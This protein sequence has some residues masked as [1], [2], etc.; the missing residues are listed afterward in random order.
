MESA[1]QFKDLTK[2]Y[3]M[4]GEHIIEI[5]KRTRTFN[6]ITSVDVVN[7]LSDEFE[8][9]CTTS[10]H[11][12]LGFVKCFLRRYHTWTFEIPWRSDKT[13]GGSP[14]DRM[15]ATAL[16]DS[17]R[18]PPPGV[19]AETGTQR[20]FEARQSFLSPL[21]WTGLSSSRNSGQN[22]LPTS[23]ETTNIVQYPRSI[24]TDAL[25]VPYLGCG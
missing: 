6:T 12:L 23:R 20:R 10:G 1:E 14:E 18:F 9:H 5:L 19:T 17:F 8:V 13:L 24:R 3:T 15:S 7:S 2:C 21:T 4:R 25:R 16:S 22:A 11:D